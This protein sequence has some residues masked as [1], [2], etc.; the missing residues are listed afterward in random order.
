MD[1][2]GA[3]EFLSRVPVSSQ[4]QD[5]NRGIIGREPTIDLIETQSP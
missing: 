2:A 5:E 3:D 4:T 1:G